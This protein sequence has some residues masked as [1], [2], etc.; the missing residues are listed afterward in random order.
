MKKNDKRILKYLAELMDDTER[1]NFETELSESD[2]LRKDFAA[3]NNKLGQVGFDKAIEVDERYFANLLP[4]VRERLEKKRRI[5]SWN[6]SFYA[7]P[8]AA[9]LVILLFLLF[10]SKVEFETQYKELAE[11]VVN[12]F[13]D[14]DVSAKYFTELDSSPADIYLTSNSDESNL[15][16]PTEIELTN[17]SYTRLID[18][19]VTED[20]RILRGLSEKDLEIV[21]EKLS[22]S[23]SQKVTK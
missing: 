19:P 18:N 5:I 13:S 1:H 16:I 22:S 8:T 6:T 2:E 11:E 21:Y 20:Y 7:T 23:T 3:I 14:E 9:A 15:Q 17:D 12:N 10:S 4:R